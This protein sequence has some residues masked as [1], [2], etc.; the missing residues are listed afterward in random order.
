MNLAARLWTY[1]AER[2]PLAR[3]VPMLAAF[4]FASVTASANLAHRP[5][6]S[7]AAYL[8]AFLLAFVFFWQLRAADEVK[9]AETDRLHRPER[10]VPRGLVS[11]R[12]IAGLGIGAALPA[13][14][15]A[16]LLDPRLVPAV[17]AVWAWMALM[18]A[19]FFRPERLRASP[20][21]YLVTHMAIMPLIDLAL[22]ACEWIPAPASPPAGIWTF[23]WMSFCNGCVME[24]GRKTWAPSQERP[25][26][27]TYSSGW[28]VDRALAAL[29]LAACGA[30][31]GLVA[32]GF[33]AG[34]PLAVAVP[35]AAALA[36]LLSAAA[37]FRAAPDAAGQ[38]RL[39]AASGIWVLAC[40][41]V[42]AAAPA[43]PAM[44]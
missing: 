21:L 28:G 16:W 10:P 5:L 18:T 7:V 33:H 44:P 29:S 26:V 34:R 43:L 31:I 25:G 38:K 30:A 8:T 24:F 36:F 6:P 42:A 1:Q 17:A 40:Y 9:D 20:L 35:G 27:E 19:E 37:R 11:L 32:Y 15:A 39:E 12:L 22:T 23:L 14:A 4:S 41:L 2:F 3:T 13:L